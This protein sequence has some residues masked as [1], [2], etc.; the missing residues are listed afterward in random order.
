[1]TQR[2]YPSLD[3]VGID[4]ALDKQ[5]VEQKTVH[6]STI[7]CEW[8][9]GERVC[10]EVWKHESERELSIQEA[11][12]LAAAEGWIVIC[13][14]PVC[15]CHVDDLEFGYSDLEDMRKHLCENGDC[16][17]WEKYIDKMQ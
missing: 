10:C 8:T 14:R 13:G 15:S 16:I 9:N 2:K 6:I 17:N 11:R 3:R 12:D 1:M 7:A 4:F 5:I